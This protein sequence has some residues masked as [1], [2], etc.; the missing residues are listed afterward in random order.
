MWCLSLVLKVIQPSY[1]GRWDLKRGSNTHAEQQIQW[2]AAGQ[3]D[4][5]RV[6]LKQTAQL[7]GWRSVYESFLLCKRSRAAWASLHLMWTLMTQRSPQWRGNLPF[8]KPET[9]EQNPTGAI[10]DKF[11]GAAGPVSVAVT[12]FTCGMQWIGE[13]IELRSRT[14]F[15]ELTSEKHRTGV[16][17]RVIMLSLYEYS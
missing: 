7:G 14:R 13:C 4:G 3:A 1:P 11:P 2:Q 9:S 15:G 8:K 16:G 17:N 5:K 10:T 6:Q 12:F